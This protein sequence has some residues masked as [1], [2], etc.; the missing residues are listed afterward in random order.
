MDKTVIAAGMNDLFFN[1]L[2]LTPYCDDSELH[3]RIQCYAKILQNCGGLGHNKIRYE[4]EFSEIMVGHEKNL[5]AY[6]YENLY[7]TELAESVKLIVTMQYHP[8]IDP[9]TEQEDNFIENDYVIEMGDEKVS[10]YG[11]TSAHLYKSFSVGFCSSECWNQC[12]FPIH[13]KNENTFSLDGEVYCVSDI[14]HF[15]DDLFVN[16]YI[17]C[18]EVAYTKRSQEPTC[19]LSSDHHGKNTLNKFSER[20]MK[21]DFVTEVINS[22]PFAPKATRF[23]EKI[24]NDGILN[25]RLIGTDRGLGIAVRTTG[26]NKIQMVYFANLLNEKYGSKS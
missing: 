7:N 25:L 5:A 6:C 11:M 2:S 3:R 20:I 23:V 16:W 10:G 9:D 4:K 14:S 12:C 26:Q 22:L 21:E 1:E 17:S 8:Y 13:K 15:D 18:H 24:G 19:R